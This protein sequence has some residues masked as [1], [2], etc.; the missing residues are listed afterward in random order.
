[1]ASVAAFEEKEDRRRFQRFKANL[2]VRCLD[3]IDGRITQASTCDIS[4]Q[5]LGIVSKEGIPEAA[6]LRIWLHFP[7]QKKPLTVEGRVA[8]VERQFSGDWRL[9]VDLN[10]P[11]LFGMSRLF[12]DKAE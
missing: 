4:A 7:D 10:K 12:R 2:P 1:M 3:L 9:G 8:W 6:P 5:G 11:E